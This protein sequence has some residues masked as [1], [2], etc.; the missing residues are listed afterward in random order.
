MKRNTSVLTQVLPVI[1]IT[2]VLS[3][4]ASAA[5]AGAVSCGP[6]RSSGTSYYPSYYTVPAGAS[7]YDIFATVSAYKDCYDQYNNYCRITWDENYSVSYYQS[8]LNPYTSSCNLSGGTWI[9]NTN[10]Y[11]PCQ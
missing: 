2:I 7:C 1:A 5:N 8:Y 3:L 9:S 4:V 11:D 10:I 6:E